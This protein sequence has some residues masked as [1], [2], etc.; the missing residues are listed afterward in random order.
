[1]HRI[2]DVLSDVPFE[3]VL[4][5]VNTGIYGG[6]GIYNQLLCCSTDHY[7]F[8]QVLVHEFG[9]SYA[10]LGDE[11]AYDDMDTVWYPSDIEPWEPN[12]TTLH[13]FQ[14]KWA[15]MVP[16]GTP[17]P[18]PLDPKVPD[19]RTVSLQDKEAM[20]RLNA[21]VG[22]VGVFEG[23]GYQTKGCFRPAQEC[24]MKVNE[25]DDFCPVCTRAI[26]RITDFYTAR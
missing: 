9:H 8:K 24:R 3:H 21:S 19:S 10:G 16:V 11:Y 14:S 20:K 17:I 1:M 2:Y 18:T 5:L 26:C 13:D 12:I 22:V 7:T 4:V 15:E 25:V 23:A 6:G